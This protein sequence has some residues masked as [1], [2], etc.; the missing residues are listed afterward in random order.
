MMFYNVKGDGGIMGEMANGLNS[1]KKNIRYDLLQKRAMLSLPLRQ[2]NEKSICQKLVP[3]LRDVFSGFDSSIVRYY[4]AF[5][6]F[7]NEPDILPLFH[8]WEGGR[9][10][11]PC[12]VGKDAPLVFRRFEGRGS[13]VAGYQGILEPCEQNE[14]VSPSVLC[15]PLVGFDR[16]GGRLGYGGGFY[17]RTL[18]SY[19][20]SPIKIGV[21]WSCQEYLGR[22]PLCPHDVLLDYVVTENEIIDFS[23]CVL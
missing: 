11:L 21:A 22:L 15:M 7:K 9:M 13:L 10:A 6:S 14:I 5:C 17:D 16:F 19:D 12:V 18:A 4:G 23:S 3:L 8:L 1:I 2:E 20:F